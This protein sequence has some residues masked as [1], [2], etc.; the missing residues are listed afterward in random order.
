MSIENNYKKVLQEVSQCALLHG[1]NPEEIRIL[2]VSKS[3]PA[4]IVQEAVDRGITLLGE[5]RVQEAKAKKEELRG[6]IDL[7]L[8]GHLQ[9]NKC[10]EA[11]KLFSLIHSLDKISTAQKL[12]DEALKI[13]KVQEVLIQV[14]TSQEETKTGALPKD[15]IPMVEQ[16]LMMNN[17][18][19]KGLMTVAPNTEDKN[20][21]ENA[22]T[23][24]RD[25]LYSVNTKLGIDLKELSMGMSNDYKI[26]I[27]SG[28]T[29]VRI[30]SGIFGNRNYN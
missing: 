19:L 10:K 3:F 1:R 26:A 16:I 24:T 28:A 22:F 14:K 20:I 5:N 7:H 12:D 13:G 2:A 9:S 4:E 8:I 25:L 29:I 11:V 18:S 15:V 30:G 6:E 17:L 23:Y 27:K 21:I